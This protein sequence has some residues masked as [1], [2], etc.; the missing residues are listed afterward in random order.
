MKNSEAA[1]RENMGLVHSCAKRFTGRGIEYDDIVQ[2][3][4]LGLVKAAD[5]FDESR[6]F[7]FS[8]YAVPLILGEMRELFRKGGPVKVSR[9]I[10]ETAA[11]VKAA[12][13]K[14]TE[15]NN[16]SPSILELAEIT[17]MGTEK[18]AEAIGACSVPQSLTADDDGEND[19]VY[20]GEEEKLTERLSLWQTIESL[21][22]NDKKLIA[23]RYYMNK[24][25]KETAELIGSTQVG[26]S[27]REKKI[28]LYMRGV[29]I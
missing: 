4:C 18:I 5:N 1:V 22:D 12:T 16:R 17:G 13:E 28:L 14:F 21:D 24:T 7:R 25:Q 3:G 6:G 26:V 23:L 20:P 15:E 19:V 9:S 8:T 2:A 29:L 27:R 10:R 11:E